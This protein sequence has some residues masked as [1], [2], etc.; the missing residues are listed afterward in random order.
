MCVSE[1]VCVRA[2]VCARFYLTPLDSRH[3]IRLR[4][5][6]TYNDAYA[7]P[8]TRLLKTRLLET[9]LL[10]TRLLEPRL[11]ETRLLETRLLEKAF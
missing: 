1:G 6:Q 10:E 9:R 2:C 7:S 3:H 4:G 11:L 5:I 8:K